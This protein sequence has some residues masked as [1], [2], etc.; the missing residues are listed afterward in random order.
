MEAGGLA[1]AFGTGVAYPFL[2]IYLHNVR[3][4]SLGTAGLVL[5]AGSAVGLAAGLA[6]GY[7]V[8]RIGARATL[9][10]SLVCSAVGFGALPF[11]R[12]E[13]HAF[14]ASAVAGV[15]NGAFWPSQSALLVGLSPENRRH[16]AYSLQR[17]ARNLG[18]GLGGLAGGLI[19]SV[20]HPG[21]FTVLFLLDAASF[22][23]FVAVLPLVPDPDAHIPEGELP[24][25]YRDVLR[26]GAFVGF[27]GLNVLFVAA[28]YAQLELFPA[29]ATNEAGVSERAIGVLFLVN[30]LVVVLAQL[31]VAKLAEGRRRMPALA[32]MTFLWAGSWTVVL[33]GGVWFEALAASLVFG[34]ALIVFGVGEC[35][36]GPVQG[37]LVA[38]LAPPRLRGRYMALS[39]MSWEMG[40][41]LGP[42][43]G[44]FILGAEPLA[45]WPLAA[46]V[47]LLA[48]AGALTLERG[49]PRELRLT[50]A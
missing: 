23:A 31:P 5:A 14:L 27:V 2:V 39:T 22:L 25:R 46:F 44:G 19:A 6:A 3:G 8:D 38:D 7:T 36:Q 15:G 49:I 24:G 1:N 17:V 43:A 32:L 26:H 33:A 21:T 13:W 12:E 34:V 30:T 40:F 18:I 45:L 10:A 35:F 50:P 9:A 48:G 16:A 42:A 37:A 29:F 41:M 4:F 28:G 47:C 11:V 20:S